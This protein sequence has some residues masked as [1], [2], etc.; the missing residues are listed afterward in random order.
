[1]FVAAFVDL[2]VGKDWTSPMTKINNKYTELPT[3]PCWHEQ[4]K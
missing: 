1:M 2:V 3:I 4:K